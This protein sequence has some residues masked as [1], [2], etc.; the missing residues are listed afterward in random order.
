MKRIRSLERP[1]AGLADYLDCEGVGA[2]WDGFRSHQAGE[3]Y[4]KLV[5]GLVD[6]Q[7]GLC[8]YCG[9]DILERDR[10]VEHVI[11]QSDP[12]CDALDYGNMIACCKGGTLQTTD[13][14]RR[15][16][17]CG[18]AKGNRV[19]RDFVDPRTLPD[20]PALIRVNFDGRVVADADSCAGFGISVARMEATIKTQ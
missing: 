5:E 9:I 13:P 14:V 3:S 1:T 7:H 8:G 18:E 19:N 16:R 17:S 4:R 2:N 15:N 20:C 11:P 12:N 10:Q 6:L